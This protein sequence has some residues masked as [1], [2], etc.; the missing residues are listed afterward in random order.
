G[1]KPWSVGCRAAYRITSNAPGGRPDAT[2]WPSNTLVL[3]GFWDRASQVDFVCVRVDFHE[4]LAVH[5]SND[6]RYAGGHPD[7]VMACVVRCSKNEDQ[8]HPPPR[9]GIQ[10]KQTVR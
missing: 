4:V 8:G 1:S 6:G 7:L 10:G 3:A 2:L 5:A 9:G